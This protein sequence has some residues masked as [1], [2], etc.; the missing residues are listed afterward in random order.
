MESNHESVLK[1]KILSSLVKVF[2]KTE[3]LQDPETIKFSA[4]KNETFSFQAAFLFKGWGTQLAKVKVESPLQD[5]ITLREVKTVPCAYPAHPEIDDHYLTTEPGLFPDL[6]SPLWKG[7]ARIVARQWG[8][9]WID[10]DIP[11]DAQPGDYPIALSFWNE[12]GE[13]LGGAQTS[14]TVYNAVLPPQTLIRTEWFHGDCLADYY[15]VP[16]FSQRHWEIVENFL[17]AAARR[18]ITMILT[19][20]FTPPL[21]TKEGGERTTIQLVGVEKNGEQY[22]FDFSRL[23]RWAALCKKCGI[24]YLEMSHLFTQWGAKAAPKIIATVDGTERRLFGWDTPA[25]GGEYAAFLAAYL[26]QVT[27]KLKE[28]GWEGKAYFHI[29]DEP[30]LSQLESYSAAKKLVEPYIGGFPILDALSSYEFYETGLVS[31][32]VCSTNHIQEFLDHDTPHLWSYYCTAQ[33][34]GVSNRFIAM[35]SSRTRIYGIQLFKYQI[36]GALH[37]AYNFYNSQFSLY[38]INP[39][40]VTDAERAFPSGDSFLVYPGADG[41]PE[42]S[43]RC[44]LMAHAMQDLRALQLL[45]GLTS[46]EYVI[47]MMEEALPAPITFMEY[48]KSDSY[49]LTLRNRVNQE[50]HRLS[51]NS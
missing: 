30:E 15:Q 51:Q 29:S 1:V 26:P 44:M 37:W 23:E 35:P 16:V 5:H 2:P 46:R 40:R 43:L 17:A 47:S 31:C 34:I 8:S 12:A 32:P 33:S 50:I 49:L 25:S 11:E 14:L 13:E 22:S 6:L 39:Y 45:A 19:P 10:V 27:A 36:E 42:E 48:P 24:Q 41:K 38:P 21:D 28:W 18:G 4:L 20:Q 9:L 3:P 7:Q